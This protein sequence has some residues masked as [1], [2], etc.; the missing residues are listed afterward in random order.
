[1]D[2]WKRLSETVGLGDGGG[3]LT[4]GEA[5]FGRVVAKA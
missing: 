2:G 3:A 5:G 1:V 4:W